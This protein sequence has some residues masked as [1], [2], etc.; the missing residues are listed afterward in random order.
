MILK[1][2]KFLLLV[3]SLPFLICRCTQEEDV[4]NLPRVSTQ[5]VELISNTEVKF[6]AMVFSMPTR[7]IQDYGFEVTKFGSNNTKVTTIES[8]GT[9]DNLLKDY[10][11]I[12][13]LSPNS[14]Y[15]VRAFLRVES[16]TYFGNSI[17]FRTNSN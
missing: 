9:S 15:S 13:D 4:L 5:K 11:L 1:R 2:I 16:F 6:S 3:V 14:N 12:I 8:L 7:S 17:E 10:Q